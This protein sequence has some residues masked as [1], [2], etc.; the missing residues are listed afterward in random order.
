M[1]RTKLLIS[2]AVAGALSAGL[3][4]SVLP[5]SAEPHTL[6]VTLAGGKQL[7]ITV[8]V[9]PGTPASQMPLPSFALPVVSVQD[10]TPAAPPPQQ[11]PPSTTTTGPSGS[12]SQGGGGAP[13][14][15]GTRR[16]GRRTTSTSP[17]RQVAT[18]IRSKRV[19]DLSAL[20]RAHRRTMRRP[21]GV[22]TPADPSFSLSQPGPAPIGVPNFFIEKFRIP[23]FLLSI[24]QA[25]GIQ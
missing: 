17:R 24:Y 5:A 13:S 20:R 22:P 2:L 12:P 1:K 11:P 19:E 7:T 9:P 25:A 16:P 3:G 6:L 4:S 15:K 23:P 8:D 14:P 18:R 10:I 21:D